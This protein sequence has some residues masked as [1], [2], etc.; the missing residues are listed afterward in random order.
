M[1]IKYLI[2]ERKL[3]FIACWKKITNLFSENILAFILRFS[4]ELIALSHDFWK[5]DGV[6]NSK[7]IDTK[8]TL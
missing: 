4:I 3:L 6:L 7:H 2:Y 5:I 8:Y 1:K